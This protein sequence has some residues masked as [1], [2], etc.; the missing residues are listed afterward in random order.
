VQRDVNYAQGKAAP[1]YPKG[2]SPILAELVKVKKLPPV[3]ERVGAEP[4]VL[5]GVDGIGKYGGTWIRLAN[6]PGDAFIITNRLSGA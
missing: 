1:W 5:G 4:L 3:A 6:A 2:E